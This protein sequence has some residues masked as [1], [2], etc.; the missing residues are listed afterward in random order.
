M[1][2]E[3]KRRHIL[4]VCG[5]FHHDGGGGG[6]RSPD[7]VGVMSTWVMDFTCVCI[8]A[9]RQNQSGRF[10]SDLTNSIEHGTVM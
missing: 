10:C 5:N 6:R 3:K 4:R 7:W 8:T 2:W 9:W 1:L